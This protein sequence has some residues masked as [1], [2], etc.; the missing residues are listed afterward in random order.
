MSNGTPAF[1]GFPVAPEHA[2][3]LQPVGL[4]VT[5]EDHLKIDVYNAA[6]GVTVA[7]IG[8]F[9]A[10]DDQR[11]EAFDR[12]VAPPTDRTLGSDSIYLGH[13]WLLDVMIVVSAGTP[14]YGQTW[15][16]LGLA[17]GTGPGG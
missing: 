7:V 5:G 6:S 13:G 8:R 16:R 15:V 14:I 17:R 1:V 10:V 4:Y 9:L 11:V 2:T 3:V 12:S